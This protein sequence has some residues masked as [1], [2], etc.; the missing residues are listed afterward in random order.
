M[1]SLHHTAEKP[2][3]NICLFFV[4]LRTHT[5]WYFKVIARLQFVGYFFT[6][7]SITVIEY[8]GYLWVIARLQFVGYFFTISSITVIEYIG[9]LW[10]IA[11]LQFVGYFFFTISIIAVIEYIGYLWVLCLC[12]AYIFAGSPLER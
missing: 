3:L 4:S 2:K 7:S 12:W 5:F 1:E 10:V 6:I 9:Y 8:I 11:R